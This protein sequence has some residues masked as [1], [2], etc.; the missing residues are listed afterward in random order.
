MP[1]EQL[2]ENK[3][4]VRD[5]VRVTMINWVRA[6]GES[7]DYTDNIAQQRLSPLGH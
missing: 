7:C 5:A 6:N 4:K 2:D 3:Q 1:Q